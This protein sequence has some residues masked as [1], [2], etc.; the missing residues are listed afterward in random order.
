MAFFRSS[1]PVYQP[2]AIPGQGVMNY[3]LERMGGPAAQDIVTGWGNS[4]E[5][6]FSLYPTST[7]IVMPHL[8]RVD[9][10]WGVPAGQ[11]YSMGLTPSG[12]E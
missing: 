6:M 1:Y 4:N 12:R 8:V 3:A 2:M 5:R 7:P 9:P 11:M 10:L